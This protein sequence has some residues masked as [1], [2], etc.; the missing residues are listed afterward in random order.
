MNIHPPFPPHRRKGSK[1]NGDP[2]VYDQFADYGLPGHAL[3]ELKPLPQIPN[4]TF[5]SGSRA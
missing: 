5:S 3:Y 2:I 1:R 4:W